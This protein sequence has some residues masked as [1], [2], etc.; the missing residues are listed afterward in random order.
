MEN[1]KTLK[2]HQ[3]VLTGTHKKRQILLHRFLGGYTLDTHEKIKNWV[4]WENWVRGVTIFFKNH[5]VK[6]GKERQNTQFGVMGCFL[7]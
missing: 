2:K 5:Q 7:F 4:N 3:N 1:S 6:R